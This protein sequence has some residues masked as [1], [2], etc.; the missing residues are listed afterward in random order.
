MCIRDSPWN[1]S[2][3]QP[4]YIVY[5]KLEGFKE[6][7]MFTR[8]E[9][10]AQELYER[11]LEPTHELVAWLAQAFNRR[12]QA[13]LANQSRTLLFCLNGPDRWSSPRV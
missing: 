12:D 2:W 6:A 7:F 11:M 10:V 8:A 13:V 1:T 9:R 4:Q 3:A 5:T